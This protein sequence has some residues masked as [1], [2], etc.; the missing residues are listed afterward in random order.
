MR[1]RRAVDIVCGAVL[2]PVKSGLH[3]VFRLSVKHMDDELLGLVIM[4]AWCIWFN[5]N[6]VRQGKTRQSTTEILR[7]DEY[8]LEEFQTAN[9]KLACH[10]TS[11]T[12]QWIPP[13]QSWY[14]I[15]T[16]GATFVN[17]QSAR[18][19]IIIPDYKGQVEAALSKDLPIP[20]G[21]MEIEEKALEEGVLFAW[22]IG[23]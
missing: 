20:L 17:T 8:L 5:R 13:A 6:V 18:V 4:V 16:N 11:N 23:V 19:G 9:F 22:D 1:R 2:R 7:K 14:K 10:E 12:V 3:P 21:P 15:N